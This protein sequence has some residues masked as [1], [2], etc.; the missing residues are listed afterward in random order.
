MGGQNQ[1]P[2]IFDTLSHLGI[3]MLIPTLTETAI[4]RITAYFFITW[5][6][7]IRDRDTFLVIFDSVNTDIVLQARTQVFKSAGTLIFVDHFFKRISRLAIC[8]GE[9]NSITI[10]VWRKQ[11]GGSYCMEDLQPRAYETRLQ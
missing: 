10:N 1:I 3:K 6:D 7:G 4:L 9:G 8:W 11:K 2:T 5:G